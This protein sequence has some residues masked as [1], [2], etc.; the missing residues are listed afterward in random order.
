MKIWFICMK[1][2]YLGVK[3]KKVSGKWTYLEAIILSKLTR[4]RKTNVEWDMGKKLK[5]SS[6]IQL[7]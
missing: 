6:R 2:Y 5:V 3:Q 1:E 7:V 4:P